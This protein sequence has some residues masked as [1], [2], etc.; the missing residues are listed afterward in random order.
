MNANGTVNGASFVPALNANGAIAPGSIVALFGSNLASTTAGAKGVPLPNILSDASVTM[1][2]IAVPLFYVAG[3]QINAQVPFEIPT[4]NVSVQVSRG[5]QAT[6]AQNAI[7]AAVSPGVFTLNAQGTGDGAFLHAT[8]YQPV[9]A[10]NPAVASE[11]I[12][13]YCTGLGATNPKVAS[14]S[15]PPSN[16][17]AVAI[18]TATVAIGGRSSFVS[19]AGLAPG[20]VGLYQINAQ[21]PAGLP[22]GSQQVTVQMNGISSNVTTITTR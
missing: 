20:F 5:S 17:T 19:F 10:L 8:N 18:A 14:G 7:V 9:N 21:I 22:A 6:V 11:T 2:G 1:N 13:I 3:G 12:L 4:G 16:Q 15:A